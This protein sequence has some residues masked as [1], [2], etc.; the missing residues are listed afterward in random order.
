MHWR[1][2]V[3]M[4]AMASLVCIGR[5]PSLPRA[6]AASAAARR[7]AGDGRAPSTPGVQRAVLE[8]RGLPRG[9][10]RLAARRTTSAT[11]RRSEPTVGGPFAL[12]KDVSDALPLD[13]E[14][15]AV[16]LLTGLE[17]HNARTGG[18]LALVTRRAAVAPALPRRPGRLRDR[19]AAHLR[20]RRGHDAAAQDHR[21][22]ARPSARS[23]SAPRAAA[24]SPRCPSAHAVAVLATEYHAEIDRIQFGDDAVGPIGADDTGKRAL[25]TTGPGPAPRP[26]RVRRAARCTPSIRAASRPRRI[27]CAPRWSATR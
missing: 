3:T 27:A 17:V 15:F 14:R 18:V 1:P 23:R 13:A 16:S 7:R 4:G 12:P 19:A 24:C 20:R 25:T 2:L 10:V 8:R 21:D 22:S 5:R 26:A 9:A 6:R 11:S